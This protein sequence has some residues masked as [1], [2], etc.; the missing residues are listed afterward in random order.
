M[1][2]HEGNEV[3]FNNYVGTVAFVCEK[4]VSILIRKGQHR[5]QDVKLVIYRNQFNQI[6][7]L[8]ESSK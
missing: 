4:S 6:R 8:K 7:L 3:I 2:F 5:S 1:I